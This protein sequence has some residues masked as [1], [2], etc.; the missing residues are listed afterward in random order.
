MTFCACIFLEFPHEIVCR[1]P[2]A[3]VRVYFRVFSIRGRGRKGRKLECMSSLLTMCHW[4]RQWN[5]HAQR[6]RR[7]MGF[8]FFSLPSLPF[9]LF[10]RDFFVQ[11]TLISLKRQCTYDIFIYYEHVV[12]SLAGIWR[13]SYT[14]TMASWNAIESIWAHSPMD[15]LRSPCIPLTTC[16]DR[17]AY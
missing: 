15:S 5:F 13:I 11:T 8:P 14:E 4:Y 12:A 7:I 9:S 10:H 6:V 17:I 3:C 16:H 1:I 2:M